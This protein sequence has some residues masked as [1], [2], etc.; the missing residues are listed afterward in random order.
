MSARHSATRKTRASGPRKRTA[1]SRSGVIL[2]S[3]AIARTAA[4]LA[5]RSNSRTR[6]PVVVVNV[7]RPRGN[8][9]THRARALT[10]ATCAFAIGRWWASHPQQ[11]Q[12]YK[13]VAAQ[14]RTHLR[15]LIS[16]GDPADGHARRHP[17]GASH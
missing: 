12:H 11:V 15:E 5:G 2:S 16:Q 14:Q 9:S 8:G 13:D 4:G 7:K 10:I 1:S 17:E 3:L 6:R